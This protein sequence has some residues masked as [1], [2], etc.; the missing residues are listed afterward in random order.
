MGAANCCRR[1]DEII[2]E[3]FKDNNQFTAIDQ[4]SYPEDTEQVF[5]SNEIIEEKN[6]NQESNQK[7]YEQE[8]SNS[9]IG[10]VYE[11]A[12]NASN[13]ENNYEEE[14]KDKSNNIIKSKNLSQDN[15]EQNER[16]EQEVHQNEKNENENINININ[17]NSQISEK[18]N[19]NN[20]NQEKTNYEDLVN[21]IGNEA[22]LKAL[23]MDNKEINTVSNTNQQSLQNNL[24]LNNYNIQQNHSENPRAID[25]KTFEPN[26]VNLKTFPIG[27]IKNPNPNVNIERKNQFIFDDYDPNEP[28][29]TNVINHNINEINQRGETL[30]INDN[31]SNQYFQQV[32]SNENDNEKQGVD[33]NQ[34]TVNNNTQA[35][36]GLDMNKVLEMQ[37]KGN[38]D[39]KKNEHI[40][41]EVQNDEN[42]NIDSNEE[43]EIQNDSLNPKDSVKKNKN[44]QINN[45]NIDMQSQPQDVGSSNINNYNQENNITSTTDNID[46]NNINIDMNNFNIEMKDL[47]ETFGSSNINNF[48]QVETTTMT[49]EIGNTDMN[50]L[51][52]SFFIKE[53]TNENI[54]NGIS[55]GYSQPI[56]TNPINENIDYNKYFQQSTQQ[57]SEPINIDLNQFGMQQNVV[58]ENEDLSKYFQQS[59]SQANPEL[60]NLN[61]YFQRTNS[62]PLDL[63]NFGTN[64]N[65]TSANAGLDLQSL[66]I[67][68]GE[69][70][71][72]TTTNIAQYGNT[73]NMASLG[74]IDL[75]NIGFDNTQQV[76]TNINN[77]GMANSS[78]S[79]STNY[80]IQN[81]VQS[82]AISYSNYASPVQS[83]SYNYSYKM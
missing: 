58:N 63:N 51:P 22:T 2:I 36:G 59:S 78:Y 60:V 35:Q 69:Q 65:S 18:S 23:K 47:P 62:E 31:N 19:I 40:S 6:K 9:K 56:S 28:Q 55:I 27:D 50:G 21:Q 7:L 12:I 66:G 29:N 38:Q 34:L 79:M 17:K 77:L 5:K 26:Y 20:E 42:Q 14:N 75:K 32:T 57:T 41:S 82:N 74:G 68:E 43:K 70:N 15:L 16:E 81:S 48:N 11:V 64:I 76:S 37:Q 30:Q 33:L 67:N 13:S 24:N 61:Q 54:N 25:L 71:T 3:D 52:S 1:P 72:V 4:N 44:N 45:V 73:E 46:M 8:V 10:G 80:Q 83:Y 49:N 53:E 39:M